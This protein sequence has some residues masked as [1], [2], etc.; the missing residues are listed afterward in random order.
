MS[1]SVTLLS[2]RADFSKRWTEPLAQHGFETRTFTP[3]EV[4][5]AV[6][7]KTAVVIDASCRELKEEEELLTCVG[8][9][10][11][12]GALPVVHLPAGASGTDDAIDEL[13]RGLVARYSQDIARIAACLPR[14]LDARRSGRFE[15]V[16]VAPGGDDVLAILGNG[17][18]FLQRRPLTPSDDGSAISSIN[19]APDAQTVT[20]RLE[21]GAQCS[22]VAGNLVHDSNASTDG[23]GELSL[24]GGEL[25]ARL[26]A[27]RLEAGLTQAELA[28]RTGI[29]RPNI[30]RVEAGRHTPS[31]ETLSRIANAI[32]VPTTQVLASR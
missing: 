18:A 14:R 23:H 15:F 16:T 17:A 8:F 26:K 9:V 28:R 31:L 2:D 22:L 7:D 20:L 11:A 3:D 32:G 6:Q 1:V 21:S 4:T 27:L 24:H 19:L 12:C 30:A 25:G 10:R 29:H 5:L 13:C